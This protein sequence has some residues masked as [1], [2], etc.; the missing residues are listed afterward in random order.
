MRVSIAI[1]VAVVAVFTSSG[2]ASASN[3]VQLQQ[4]VPGST[5]NVENADGGVRFLRKSVEDESDDLAS[6][7]E[8]GALGDLA[9]KAK[10]YLNGEQRLAK[11]FKKTDEQLMKKE[12]GPNFLIEGAKRLEKA[13]WPAAK[14]EQF[15][16]KG[17]QYSTFW[18]N[19]FKDIRGT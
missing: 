11:L 16:V 14:V 7:E 8:R 6:E 2:L 13:G 17:E 15:K 9:K 3:P 1:L 10:Q 19:N 4:V 12:L 18:Y 5:N